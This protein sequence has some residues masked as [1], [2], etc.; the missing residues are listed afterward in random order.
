MNKPVG[1]VE[2]F[3][4]GTLFAVAGPA[5]LVVGLRMLY[6]EIRPRWWKR[7]PASIVKL[8]IKHEGT[9]DGTR[10]QFLPI[11]EYEYVFDG[12]TFRGTANV[13]TTGTRE[14]ATRFL[15][16]YPVAESVVVFVNPKKPAQSALNAQVTPASCFFVAVGSLFTL[17]EFIWRA[18]LMDYFHLIAHF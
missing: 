1:S 9:P 3:V 13:F 8:E 11:L 5:L 6:T 12:A 15:S 18:D 4:W 16:Q 10:Q 14:S 7:N 2:S 17:V